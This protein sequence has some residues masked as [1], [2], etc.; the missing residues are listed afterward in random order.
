LYRYRESNTVVC[1][2]RALSYH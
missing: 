2:M 1:L